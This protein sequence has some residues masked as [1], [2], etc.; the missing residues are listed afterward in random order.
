MFII[1]GGPG[2]VARGDAWLAAPGHAG[3]IRVLPSAA[4][5]PR[6]SLKVTHTYPY[7]V[8]AAIGARLR[9]SR[10]VLVARWL[11]R[12]HARVT[13][14]PEQV[15]D[16]DD[17]LNHVP[18][19]IDGIAD[20]VEDPAQSPVASEQ[21]QFKAMRLAELRHAQGFD[22]Y[23]ILKE[24]EILAAIVFTAYGETMDTLDGTP[25]A[26][27]LFACAM[28]IREAMEL[29]RQA[30]MT[31]FLRLSSERVREREDRLR[32][33]NVLVSHELKNRVGAIRGAAQLLD[34]DWIDPP[35]RQ[36]FQRMI[37]DNAAALQ[38][39]LENLVTLSRIGSDARQTRNVLLPQA[40]SEAVRQLR[41]MAE[42]HGVDV[43]VA[44]EIPEIEVDAAGVE[45]CLVNYI[46]N[47]IKYSDREKAVRW[48]R[49]G[50][51]FQH[52]AGARSGELVVTVTDNG[53]GVPP[54]ARSRL[55]EQFYRAH[56]EA[57]TGVEG[58]GL[59]LSIVRQMIETLGGRTWAEFPKGGGSSF[60]FALPSRRSEDAAAAGVRRPEG[61]LA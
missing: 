49:V 57:A 51:V 59:G 24:S 48:V 7:E 20:Y 1:A 53:I 18:L 3:Q 14:E 60:S 15:F 31:H 32:R 10:E 5:L 54:P 61:V 47:S 2:D 35:Q 23:E 42:A 58:T 40:V 46:S 12:I 13:L 56:D 36:R 6:T 25:P 38:H 22:A 52:A 44:P 11:E 39:T 21:V 30:M 55:F 26:R 16:S 33:F 37:A 41:E 34:E 45:L 29:I 9:A 8:A 50:A 19:L 43:E 17:L 4:C 27:D 28:R